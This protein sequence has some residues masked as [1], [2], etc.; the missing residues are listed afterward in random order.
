MKPICKQNKSIIIKLSNQTKKRIDLFYVIRSAIAN[1]NFCDYVFKSSDSLV[2]IKSFI[3]GARS[4][5]L[6][7]ACCQR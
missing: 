4:V 5:P 3:E 2:R 6:D 7:G 1:D